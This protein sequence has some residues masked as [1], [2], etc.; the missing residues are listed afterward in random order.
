MAGLPEDAWMSEFI[1]TEEAQPEDEEVVTDEFSM[2][3]GD[4]GTDVEQG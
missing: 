2:Y 3:M 1:S 4:D